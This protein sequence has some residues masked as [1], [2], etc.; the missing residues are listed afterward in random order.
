MLRTSP[1]GV[2]VLVCHALWAS[3]GD[4]A[5]VDPYWTLIHDDAVLN[6]LKLTAEQRKSWRAVLDPLDLRFF[7]LRNQAA[8]E[9]EKGLAAIV[10]DA[11]SQLAKIL[12]PQQALRLEQIVVRA[13]GPAAL[14]R[15]DLANRLKLTRQQLEEV[16]QAIQTARDGRLKLQSELR[17]AKIATP[18]AERALAALNIA[19]RDAVNAA[20][21]A[22]QKQQLVSLLA[23]DFDLAKLGRTRFK[24]PDLVGDS[25]AW[26]GSPPLSPADLRGRV[27]VVHFFAFGCINCIHNYPTYRQW[28]AEL[29]GK[30]VQII[31]IH[32]PET[33]SEHNVETLKTKLA[34]E[35]LEFP[36]LV[37]NERANWNAWGNSMWPSVYILDR[38]G[39]VRDFWAGELRWQ[40]ATGDASLRKTIESLVAEGH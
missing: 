36:V 18:A 10:A 39:Y 28:Q 13:Q 21:L 40:G 1:L 32:T 25:D 30:D 2:V 14:L 5:P 22:E 7:P 35:R 34:A 38:R 15:D 17:A 19:E 20:L 27:V 16:R 3:A 11:R 23:R 12:K 37:D 24:A 4:L 9:A 31:G 33:K 8:A 29:A 6:D 26:L